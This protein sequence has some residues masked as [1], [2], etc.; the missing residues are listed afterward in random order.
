MNKLSQLATDNESLEHCGHPVIELSNTLFVS[1]T[2]IFC[3]QNE[4]RNFNTFLFPETT[5]TLII[6]VFLFYFKERY[7]KTELKAFHS[8]S[9]V[10]SVNCNGREEMLEVMLVLCFGIAVY[11][12]IVV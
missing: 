6:Y 12:A 2:L 4:T 5:N 10:T 11:I 3:W 8:D 9:L 1:I 7:I